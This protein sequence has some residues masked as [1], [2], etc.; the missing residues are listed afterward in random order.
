MITGKDAIRSA[1]MVISYIIMGKHMTKDEVVDVKLII[2]NVRNDE[3]AELL[4][5]L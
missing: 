1:G 3:N 4:Q 2:C 5:I